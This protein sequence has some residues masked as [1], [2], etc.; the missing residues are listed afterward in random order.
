MLNQTGA[1]LEVLDLGAHQ[2][3]FSLR[4]ANAGHAVVALDSDEYSLDSLRQ[5][6]LAEGRNIQPLVMNLGNPTPADGWESRET[7][8]FTQRSTQRFDLVMAFALVHHLR[9]SQGV[10]FDL[11]I[12][13]MARMTRKHLLIEWIA[14]EDPM[15]QALLK[16]FDYFPADLSK[17]AF[18]ASLRRFFTIKEEIGI[19]GGTR[20]IYHAER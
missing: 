19:D 14:A 13:A 2:G 8:S 9:F 12:E 4:A 20:W 6:A 15:V 10:P 17:A 3:E 16:R 5:V 11:Q 1:P 18:E 7:L